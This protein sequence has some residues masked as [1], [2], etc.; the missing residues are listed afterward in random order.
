MSV[1]HYIHTQMAGEEFAA[2][3]AGEFGTSSIKHKPE[4]LFYTHVYD[5]GTNNT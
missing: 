1:V 2:V 3:I 5:I 4:L